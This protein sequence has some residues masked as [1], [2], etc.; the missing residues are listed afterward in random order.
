MSGTII[1]FRRPK[2]APPA[3][4]PCCSE[5]GWK[6][7]KE[8]RADLSALRKALSGDQLL[9]YIDCPE[10]GAS[11]FWMV[12][13][14]LDPQH[15]EDTVTRSASR[16]AK[17]QKLSSKFQ[18]WANAELD[19]ITPAGW[20]GRQVAPWKRDDVN[21][22]RSCR[23][24]ADCAATMLTHKD[25]KQQTVRYVFVFVCADCLKAPEK[26]QALGARV[27]SPA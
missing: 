1:P 10:C 15:Q 26:L 12:K 20:K 11:L 25:E 19:R 3:P 7:P 5:C 22:C 23:A 2:E 8:V 27:L 16:I 6:M 9:L 18:E 13:F 4:P 14:Q 17:R 24:R 21:V